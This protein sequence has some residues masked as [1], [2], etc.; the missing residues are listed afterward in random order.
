MSYEFCVFIEF[1]IC[2]YKIYTTCLLNLGSLY[3]VCQLHIF[4]DVSHRFASFIC[5]FYKHPRTG[6]VLPNFLLIGLSY[7]V[8]R[9]LTCYI[10]L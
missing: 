1:S 5:R 9:C 10:K 3:Y 8:C 2:V 7:F 4:V 6:E